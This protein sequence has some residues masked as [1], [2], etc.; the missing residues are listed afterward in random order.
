VTDICE[1]TLLHSS[2]LVNS[3]VRSRIKGTQEY[4]TQKSI[5][6]LYKKAEARSEKLLKR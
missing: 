2:P 6:T 1:K 5:A 4:N 3:L